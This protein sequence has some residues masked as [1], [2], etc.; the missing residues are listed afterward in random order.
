[1][2]LILGVA[3]VVFISTIIFVK[4]VPSD[5]PDLNGGSIFWVALTFAIVAA[6]L[7]FIAAGIL[8]HFV[9]VKTERQVTESHELVSAANTTRTEGSVSGVFVVFSGR[10]AD[11]AYYEYFY[12]DSEDDA[13][14]FGREPAT[15][16]VRLIEFDDPEQ[17]PRLE[18][19]AVVEV[20]D[21]SGWW[22]VRPFPH[23]PSDKKTYLY[24]PEGSVV[25]DFNFDHE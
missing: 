24:V 10:V 3:A 7:S 22:Y 6:F 15:D 8:G 2:G 9:D 18:K 17:Q 20:E 11:N 5:D 14:V 12:R 25:R 1:M 4:T 23:H 13:I 21:K 16:D 19:T